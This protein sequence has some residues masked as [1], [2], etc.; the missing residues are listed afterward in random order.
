MDEISFTGKV[1][2]PHHRHHHH[3][4]HHHRHRHRHHQS[5]IIIHFKCHRPT[6]FYYDLNGGKKGLKF[7]INI[8]TFIIIILI[9]MPQELGQYLNSV[10]QLFVW[11]ASN[12]NQL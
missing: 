12:G 11:G 1:G 2:H 8:I 5:I 10:G 4:H 6:W 7:I 9:I 3:P